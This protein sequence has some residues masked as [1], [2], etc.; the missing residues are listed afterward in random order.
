MARSG[1]RWPTPG[2]SGPPACIGLPAAR[3][4]PHGTTVLQGAVIVSE[5]YAYR[6][7]ISK[8]GWLSAAA[9]RRRLAH[10]P[11]RRRVLR[12]RLR[13]RHGL[14]GGHGLSCLLA[15]S[16]DFLP[17]GLSPARGRPGPGDSGDRNQRLWRV[18]DWMVR[19]HAPSASRRCASSI[20]PLPSRR[21]SGCWRSWSPS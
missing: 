1:C 20:E 2:G 14:D 19:P 21:R 7:G 11:G 18:Q 13:P 16:V 12:L 15:G 3:P 9:D 5:P 10:L 8:R 4:R 17:G 6:H